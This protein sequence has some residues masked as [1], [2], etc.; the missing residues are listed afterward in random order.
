MPTTICPDR[1]RS[2]RRS[3]RPASHPG[4][5]RGRGWVSSEQVVPRAEPREAEFS[6]TIHGEGLE[7]AP[8][9]GGFRRVAQ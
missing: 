3:D 5:A 4:L 6:V 9:S 8:R 7:E 1:V 2:A